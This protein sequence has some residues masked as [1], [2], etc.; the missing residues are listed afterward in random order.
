MFT[1]DKNVRYLFEYMIL[2]IIVHFHRIL[3]Q[4]TIDRIE[5]YRYLDL[6]CNDFDNDILNSL[7]LPNMIGD[8][9]SHLSGYIKIDSIQIIFIHVIGSFLP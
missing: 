4:F 1:K 7:C 3:N 2:R 5:I 6:K 8:K 9:R